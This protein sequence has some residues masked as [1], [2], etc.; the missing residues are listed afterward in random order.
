MKKIL[1]FAGMILSIITIHAAAQEGGV[2]DYIIGPG[3]VL[4]I[5]SWNNAALTM[6]ATVL[7]DGKIHF[8]LVGD[9]MAGGKSVAAFKQEL[10]TKLSK[11]VG[12]PN[13]SVMVQQ[14]NSMLIY[15]IGKVNNP[16]RFVLNTN[17][18]VLQ[19]LAMAG[20]LNPFAKKNNISVFRETNGKT[21]ILP[22]EYETV[23]EGKNL[24]QNVWLQRGDVVVV[25]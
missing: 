22:F 12:E 16:G 8:P 24:G 21:D 23:T 1:I 5:S 10:E 17:V 25:P 2:S 9:S 7:P 18:N 4:M 14:V 19:A 13:L 20:G 15:I 3:D 11:F 6:S